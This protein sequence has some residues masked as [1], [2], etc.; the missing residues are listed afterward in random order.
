MSCIWY[1]LGNLDFTDTGD[2]WLD[3][4][5]T[6][7]TDHVYR[8]EGFWYQYLTSFHWSLTQMTPG[9]IQIN[10]VNSIERQ[11]TIIC[12]VFGLFAFS[13][14]VSSLSAKMMEMKMKMQHR[15]HMLET[16]PIFVNQTKVSRQLA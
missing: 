14:L 8:G 3:L 1:A 12:L 6:P 5:V 13:T 9:T 2:H 11:F 4:H 7:Q 16:M 15:S 10:A